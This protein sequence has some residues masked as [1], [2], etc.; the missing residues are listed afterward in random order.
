MICTKIETN[1]AGYI[2]CPKCGKKTAVR[3]K[4]DTKLVMFPLYCSWCKKE[5]IIT[6]N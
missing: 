4:T 6:K 3:I 2:I 5:T 1:A